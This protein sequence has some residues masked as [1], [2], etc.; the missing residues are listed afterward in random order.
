MMPEKC[1]YDSVTEHSNCTVCYQTEI[2]LS[3]NQSESKSHTSLTT[4]CSHCLS[5][6][7]NQT[8]TKSAHW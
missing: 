3:I 5:F 8:M 1:V 6:Y 2:K 4:L 7:G